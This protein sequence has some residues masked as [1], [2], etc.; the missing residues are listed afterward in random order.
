M[1][2]RLYY[3]HRIAAVYTILGRPYES[4]L[5]QQ[6]GGQAMRLSRYVISSNNWIK[7]NQT[8]RKSASAAAC[9]NPRLD[10]AESPFVESGFG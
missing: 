5:C 6:Y 3:T 7:S 4:V 10:A 1:N 8:A 9:A 2:R